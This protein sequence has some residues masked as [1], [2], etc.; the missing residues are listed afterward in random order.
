MCF[1][2]SAYFH[3]LSKCDMSSKC[4]LLLLRNTELACFDIEPKILECLLDLPK[5]PLTKDFEDGLHAV[6]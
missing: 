5:G 3:C 6:R 1:L 2:S 4:Q